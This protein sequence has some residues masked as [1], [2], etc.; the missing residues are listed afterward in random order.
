M[1]LS[2]KHYVDINKD[3]DWQWLEKK[4][5]VNSLINCIK[6]SFGIVAKYFRMVLMTLLSLFDAD[7]HILRH[8]SLLR[9]LYIS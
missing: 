2:L 9:F 6:Y 8:A 1:P 7:I 5:V 3:H 4:S